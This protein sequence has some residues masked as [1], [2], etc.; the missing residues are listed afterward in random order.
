MRR[1]ITHLQAVALACGSLL[2]AHTPDASAQTARTV[3]IFYALWHCPSVAGTYDLSNI[4]ESDTPDAL[5]P[6][7]TFHWWGR[8]RAGY[9]CLSQNDALLR[10]HATLLKAA[11]IDYIY[12]DITN[13]PDTQ[14]IDAD[15]MIVKPFE[16]LLAVW[17]GMAAGSTPKIIPWVTVS[18]NA[19][20]A[21]AKDSIQYVREKMVGSSLALL[22]NNK[23]V[24]FVAPRDGSYATTKISS[25]ATTLTTVK[26]WAQDA[27]GGAA[28]EWGFIS[29]CSDWS[30]FKASRGQT[31]C[32]QR[33]SADGQQISVA[34]AF[35]LNWISYAQ[36]AVPKFNGMTLLQQM[37]TAR[38]SNRP[39]VMIT[40][41]N[42]WVVQRASYTDPVTHQYYGD[43]LFTDQYNQEYNRDL[44]PATRSGTLYYDLL[45]RSVA[46]LR[47]NTSVTAV[48]GS[49]GQTKG[50]I[51]GVVSNR[52]N[53]WACS[54]G[55]R[56]PVDVHLYVGGP[57]GVGTGIGSYSSD[58]ASTSD[59][60]RIA[61]AN[62]CG[63]DGVAY[64]F[65]IRL[66]RPV[67]L[68]H[69]GKKIYVYAIHPTGA[70][71]NNATSNSGLFPVPAP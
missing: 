15:R 27:N 47:S 66:P 68:A 48:A 39:Y 18:P 45:K 56:I 36:T 60:D 13:W 69:Q 32:N 6:V 19:P 42:E 9:Y 2:M 55:A 17:G 12:V 33:G 70:L 11:G 57:A 3:G 34:P 26:M 41:W 50:V 38:L 10:E 22:S 28:D 52:V 24:V 58:F 53:G 35:A 43:R 46:A 5:G 37:E 16:R 59:A 65:S 40:G 20:P 62:A 71:P 49:F 1:F 21:G 25:Y 4:L 51:D 8:P 14:S 31:A 29:R 63:S 44:E 61:V 30:G 7:G 64:R 67:R 23:P 54:F